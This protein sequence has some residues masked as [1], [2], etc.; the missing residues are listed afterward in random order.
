MELVEHGQDQAA[1]ESQAK[2][3]RKRRG[4]G[5]VK[6]D[7]QEKAHQPELD[8]VAEFV[9]M[10]DV[11]VDID[12]AGREQKDKEIKR[13]S[14]QEVHPFFHGISAADLLF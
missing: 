12:T 8:E 6:P 11:N 10:V 7:R 14:G 1:A 5:V 3:G 9:Q 2:L 4:K 13:E